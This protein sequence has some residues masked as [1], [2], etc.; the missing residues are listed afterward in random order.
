MEKIFI[1]SERV[2]ELNEI[3]RKVVTY[4]NIKSHKKP[5][6][7]P[8]PKRYLFE[9]TTGGGSNCSPQPFKG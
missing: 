9:K 2:E 6:L 8:V 1:S 7:H 4:D 5:G 3:F